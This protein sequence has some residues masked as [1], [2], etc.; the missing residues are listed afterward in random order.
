MNFVA[1]LDWLVAGGN[2]RQLLFGHLGGC[3]LEKKAHRQAEQD[4]E[5]SHETDTIYV[6]IHQ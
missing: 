4:Q 3:G 1:E 6:K 5:H 2:C